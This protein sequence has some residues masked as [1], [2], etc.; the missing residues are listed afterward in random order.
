MKMGK[1]FG[2]FAG[3]AIFIGCLGLL[4]LASFSAER[5]TKEIGIRKILG[6]SVPAVVRLLIK[7]FVILVGI[8]NL[9]AWPIAYVLMQGWLRN[10]AFRVSF[11]LLIFLFAGALTLLFSLMTVGFL[12]LRAALSNPVDSLRYE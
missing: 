6:A 4:G 12:A 7:E 8:A 3:L 11:S 10:F 5:R 9:I 2:V 1:I